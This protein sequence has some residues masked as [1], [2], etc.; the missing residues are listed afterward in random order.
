[1]TNVPPQVSEIANWII[2]M[3]I[4][5]VLVLA[6]G[7]PILVT[8]IKRWIMDLVTREFCQMSQAKCRENMT[9]SLA[10]KFTNL[11]DTSRQEHGMIYKEIKENREGAVKEFGE[12]RKD[13]NAGLTN[14][15]TL[16][17][18]HIQKNGG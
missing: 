14:L 17:I 9:K 6:V 5:A 11:E 18:G 13:I 16:L 12:L 2:Y 8:M 1:M 7:S 4:G 15:T 3:N 10:D